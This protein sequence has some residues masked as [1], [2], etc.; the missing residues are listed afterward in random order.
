MSISYHPS[1]ISYHSHIPAV[2]GGLPYFYAQPMLVSRQ[3][4]GVLRRLFDDRLTIN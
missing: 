2:S 4:G 3:I 1:A